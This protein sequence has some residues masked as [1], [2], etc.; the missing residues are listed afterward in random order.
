[1]QDLEQ[2]IQQQ[3]GLLDKLR[4]ECRTLTDKLEETS[5]QYKYGINC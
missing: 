4:G 5:K 3:N 2:L 1:M